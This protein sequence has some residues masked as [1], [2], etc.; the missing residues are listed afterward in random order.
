MSFIKKLQNQPQ[1][2]RKFIFW[3]V[4][5]FSA[6]LLTWWWWISAKERLIQLNGKTL[7][8]NAGMPALELPPMPDASAGG[9][10]Q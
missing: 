3:L 10:V 9:T 6:V 4:I 1:G 8:E 7:F 2:V 5:I